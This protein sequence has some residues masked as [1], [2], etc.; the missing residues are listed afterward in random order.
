MVDVALEIDLDAAE[1]SRDDFE[2]ALGAVQ[3]H[4]GVSQSSEGFAV[5]KDL[6]PSLDSVE[7]ALA[8]D[9]NRVGWALLIEV[10]GEGQGH[11]YIAEY[12]EPDD[13]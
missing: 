6:G 10:T 13:G 3:D 8:A 9:L 5:V 1:M 11:F 12:Q 4:F 2:A 7:T